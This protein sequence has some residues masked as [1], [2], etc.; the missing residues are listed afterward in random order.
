[1]SM[2][3]YPVVWW[4]KGLRHEFIWK[5]SWERFMEGRIIAE[6][7]MLRVAKVDFICYVVVTV[8]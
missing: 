2:L 5:E 7:V 4:R 8:V 6:G 1:M 3:S